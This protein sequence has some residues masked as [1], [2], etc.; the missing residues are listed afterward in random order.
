MESG[1]PL[2][3]I[4]RECY[5]QSIDLGMLLNVNPFLRVSRRIDGNIKDLVLVVG[6]VRVLSVNAFQSSVARL[7]VNL[8][9]AKFN[10]RRHIYYRPIDASIFDSWDGRSLIRD[11]SGKYEIISQCFPVYYRVR[12]FLDFPLK[13]DMTFNHQKEFDGFVANLPANKRENEYIQQFNKGKKLFFDVKKSVNHMPTYCNYWHVELNVFSFNDDFN[14]I[15][16]GV[17]SGTCKRIL[18]HLKR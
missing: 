17:S 6:G 18:K 14:P 1:Y 8:S 3:I 4:P 12:D 16:P 10:A 9:G 2:Q 15:E 5:S 13:Q 7:S 11:F